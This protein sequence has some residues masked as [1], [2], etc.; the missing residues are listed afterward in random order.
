MQ[1]DYI[2]KLLIKAREL[3]RLHNIF[4]YLKFVNEISFKYERDFPQ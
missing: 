3:K 2:F 4:F 1:I